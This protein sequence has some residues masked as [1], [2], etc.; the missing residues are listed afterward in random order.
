MWLLEWEVPWDDGMGK[1]RCHSLF[2]LKEDALEAGAEKLRVGLD[3]CYP[4]DIEMFL[5]PHSDGHYYYAG[6]TVKHL[7]VIKHP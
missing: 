7:T 5:C 1:E 4:K 3:P 2:A 6:V